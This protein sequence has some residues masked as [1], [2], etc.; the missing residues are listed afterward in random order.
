MWG[1]GSH[2]YTL[3]DALPVSSTKS[4]ELRR[5]LYYRKMSKIA[6]NY[7]TDTFPTNVKE[8][9]A[10]KRFYLFP[11]EERKSEDWVLLPWKTS[12]DESSQR[13][14]FLGQ[15]LIFNNYN[16]FQGSFVYCFMI[17]VTGQCIYKVP[18]GLKWFIFSS[19]YFDWFSLSCYTSPF[20]IPL[21]IN[22]QTLPD[23]GHGDFIH[24]FIRYLLFAYM[25]HRYR[26]S[27]WFTHVEYKD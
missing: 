11:G 26:K 27:G 10:K 22:L 7:R 4:T 13:N 21:P 18:V 20:A 16:Y 12:W 1:S 14:T 5:H 25:W 24:S 17:L 15:E 3:T 8:K 6:S 23:V 19:L 2:G 9:H